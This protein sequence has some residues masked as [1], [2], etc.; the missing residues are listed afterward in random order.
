MEN[1]TATGH[2]INVSWNQAVAYVI[3]VICLVLGPL[4]FWQYGRGLFGV[5]AL[6]NFFV[7]C[8]LGGAASFGFYSGGKRW[9]IGSVLGLVAGLTVAALQVFYPAYFEKTSMYDK[10]IALLSMAA[11][12]PCMGVL[13]WILKRDKRGAGAADEAAARAA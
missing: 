5:N 7:M 13:S 11:A 12:A 1:P 4:V 10:E 9:V 6:V 8:G 2:T 3:G